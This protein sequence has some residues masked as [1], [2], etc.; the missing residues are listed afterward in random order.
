MPATY[1][2]ASKP[3]AINTLGGRG[4]WQLKLGDFRVCIIVVTIIYVP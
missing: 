3:G 4:S 1:R 2:I